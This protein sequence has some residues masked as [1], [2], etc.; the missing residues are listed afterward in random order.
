[1]LLLDIFR[2][3]RKVVLM[4]SLKAMTYTSNESAPFSIAPLIDPVIV[5][6]GFD[7][8]CTLQKEPVKECEVM[9]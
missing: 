3:H 5:L 6:S 7:H 1:M 9:S 8:L 4:A 2:S